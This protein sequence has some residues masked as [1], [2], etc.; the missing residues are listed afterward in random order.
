MS[1]TINGLRVLPALALALLAMFV[2]VNAGTAVAGASGNGGP[3]AVVA[4]KK[5]KSKKKKKKKAK[6]PS[7]SKPQPQ[8]LPQP[9]PQPQPAQPKG[10][11]VAN[12]AGQ[13][14][15][16]TGPDD[17][18]VQTLSV[19]QGSYV[20]TAKVELGNNAAS[21]NSVSCKLL[22]GFNPIDSGTEDLTPLA[23]FS[24]TMTLTA[25]STGGSLKIACSGDKPAQARNRV[26]TAVGS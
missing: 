15:I 18:I 8:P 9:Q 10:P 11:F 26:I 23:T 12:D 14:G 3:T 25:A 22:E 20:V 5:K 2:A 1:S 24:R 13:T 4:H 16:G 17:T 7:Q 19:P 6:K 21:A